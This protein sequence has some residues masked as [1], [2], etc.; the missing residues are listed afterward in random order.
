MQQ[1]RRLAQERGQ[2]TRP[3]IARAT[4]LSLVAVHQLMQKLC[5]EGDMEDIGWSPSG[6]GRPARLYRLRIGKTHSALFR[7]LRT[8][9]GQQQGQ[10]ELLN[11]RGDLLHHRQAL[12]SHLS[13]ESLDGWLDDTR[14]HGHLRRIVLQIPAQH[15][16]QNIIA[17]LTERYACPV[18]H[19]TP[20]QALA[21][22]RD[23]TVTLCLEKGRV[24]DCTLRRQ[25]HTCPSGDLGRLPLPASWET[26]DYD[27]HT[28][29]EEMISRLLLILSC[30]LAPERFVLHAPFWTPRLLR[31]IRYNT[32]AKMQGH[33][34]ALH[35]RPL[36]ETA[37]SQALRLATWKV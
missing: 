25:G 16:P 8:E 21:D 37:V 2:L 5:R 15:L 10:L 11:L 35:F 33:S 24:P 22:P 20:A 27:D 9:R 31:R 19:L 32:S 4:G 12:F 18:N 36:T 6:G 3:E 26:M 7:L 34:P 13:T 23:E 1:I 17:H 29:L 30:T 28:L 14:R